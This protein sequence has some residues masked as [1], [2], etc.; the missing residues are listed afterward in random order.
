MKLHDREYIVFPEV[1]AKLNKA[2]SSLGRAIMAF[3][4]MP[5]LGRMG[6]DELESWMNR[7]N[8]SDDEKSFLIREEDKNSA[9][10]RILDWG[11]LMEANKDFIDFHT[12]LQTNRIFLSPDI[13]E[14]L[15]KIGSL[16]RAS[17]VAK[18]MDRDGYKLDEGKSFLLEAYQKY[19]KEAKPIMVEIETLVQGKLFPESQG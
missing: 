16:M 4:E 19:E 7:S 3:R 10:S 17:W 15:D 6:K 1:W 11:D 18:K 13:K 14:R 8:L 12:C 5:D 9:Y 2:F